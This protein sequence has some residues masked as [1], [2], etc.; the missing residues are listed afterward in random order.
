MLRGFVYFTILLVLIYIFRLEILYLTPYLICVSI[1]TI[2]LRQVELR[3][4]LKKRV[5]G[6]RSGYI[7]VFSDKG[8]IL[9]TVKIGRET[10]KGSRMRSH[11][12]AAPFGCIVWCNFWVGD[13]VYAENYLH[14]RYRWM[15]VRKDG[16]WFFVI[17]LL[18]LIDLILL[19]WFNRKGR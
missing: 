19:G 1:P 2:L 16:E 9:P 6:G 10:S 12:T 5:Q 14:D 17:N 11:R 15:R 8:Q 7:Y 4:N 13:S 18:M 3:R